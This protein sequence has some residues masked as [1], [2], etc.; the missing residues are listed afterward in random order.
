MTTR[1]DIIKMAREAGLIGNPSA[2]VEWYPDAL[3]RFFYMAQ[4]A[5]REQCAMRCDRRAEVLQKH[6]NKKSSI[7]S[8]L[9]IWF[10]EGIVSASKRNAAAIR[11]R[12][13]K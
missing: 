9:A 11:A 1:E 12:G 6:L 7:M 3:E 10:T 13:N 8:P 2:Y 4:A 5:E